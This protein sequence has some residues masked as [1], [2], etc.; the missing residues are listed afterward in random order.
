M[1]FQGWFEGES[2]SPSGFDRVTVEYSI[3]DGG[4]WIEFPVPI[5]DFVGTPNTG[6]A[7][8]V[9]YSNNGTGL[10][11]DFQQYNFALPTEAQGMQD[12]LIRFLFESGDTSYN[13][14]RGFAVDDVSIDID[15]DQ[16]T[17]DFED[18][19]ADAW[20]RDPAA[21][22]GAPFWHILDTPENTSIISPEINP[23]LVT[24]AQGDSGALPVPPE[25]GGTKVAWFGDDAT[26]TF[27]GPD[28]ANR[29][30][31]P[32]PFVP[33]P[34]VPPPA[35][36]NPVDTLA[37]L[38][39]PGLGVD[40][41]VQAL[42]GEVLIGVRG[43]AAGRGGARA[44]Q[45]GLTF[46]PLSQVRQIPVGSI[47]DTRKGSVRVQSARDSRGTRQNGDFAR[48]LFQVLQSRKRSAKGL[49]EVRLKG[50]SFASCKTRSRKGRGATTS[51]SRRIRRLSAN[52]RGRFRTRGRQSSAT[53]RGTKW[54]TTDRC[55]GTLTQVT[56]GKVAVRDF[57]R[58]KTIVV[59]AGKSYLARVRR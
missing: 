37:E 9:G 27:C 45:K 5:K 12:V 19:S 22:P 14:F 44:S 58:K 3:D 18:S 53:V 28:Y 30:A 32:P 10:A 39:N 49:T 43:A 38:P 52:T 1:S 54:T 50:S 46:V 4:S 33:P 13:G 26:G 31:A 21:G 51:A 55:D 56:R 48:G 34:V 59:K 42:R 20:P 15:G 6:G 40:V 17:E 7:S 57:R 36:P 41:N 23:D 2:V 8:D 29:F 24:L 25:T 11:P 47:L 16:L 35:P